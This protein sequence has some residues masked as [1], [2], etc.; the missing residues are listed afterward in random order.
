MRTGCES[1]DD[2]LNRERHSDSQSDSPRVQPET[3][4]LSIAKRTL[5]EIRV[6]RFV[7]AGIGQERTKK[8]VRF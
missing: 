4:P 6:Q 7:R 5:R 2:C 1:S 8:S 3:Y